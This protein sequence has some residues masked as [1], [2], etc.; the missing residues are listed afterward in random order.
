MTATNPT[1]HPTPNEP[2][3]SD[4]DGDVSGRGRLAKN[5]VASW[6][7]QF[8]VIAGGFILPRV[9]NDEIGQGAL[10]VWDFAW[11]LTGLFALLQG[12]IVSSVNRFVAK[13]RALDDIDGISSAVSSVSLVLASLAAIIF[14]LTVGIA[15]FIPHFLEDKLNEFAEQARWVI[16]LLGTSFAIQVATSAFGGIITG[17]HRWDIQ[18]SIHAVV[19]FTQF[20][21]MIIAV[22]S[23]GG[24]IAMGIIVLVCESLG[25][26][27][28]ILFAYRLC[29]G[30]HVRFSY[31]RRKM[32]GRMLSFGGKSLLPDLGGLLEYQLINVLI[33]YCLHV[34]TLAVYARPLGL[35]RQAGTLVERFAYVL[36]PTASSLKATESNS[37]LRDLLTKATRAGL[38]LALPMVLGLSI[39]GD[40][41]LQVWMGE[42]YSGRSS[43]ILLIVLAVGHL[44]YMVQL[45]IKNILAG[46]NAHGRPG[47]ANFLSAL[48][49]AAGAA[50]ALLFFDQG[51]V[52][53]ALAITIPMTLVNGIYVP[54]YACRKLKMDVLPYAFAC[55]RGPILCAIPFSACLVGGRYAFP[56][57]PWGALLS[58]SVAGGLVLLPL[59]WRLV[60]PQK[61]KD[62]LTGKVHDGAGPIVPQPS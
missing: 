29:P 27:A 25:R 23:G 19:N 17:H 49:S 28:R 34:T 47:V 45:P 6:L 44:A 4:E 12:G 21:A 48:V 58:G 3:A 1:D 41:L 36:T 15:F 39:M 22:L 43:W 35:V 24:L 59:Y 53:V 40:L 32:M 2:L 8:V 62:K 54:I 56:D 14:A 42:E 10:G 52:S 20:L 31:V 50:V 30:L 26:G 57:Q 33:T 11:S 46:L 9:V 60:V 51:L 18:S 37:A 5:V 61:F 13:H 38:Y 7:A 16:L 55:V